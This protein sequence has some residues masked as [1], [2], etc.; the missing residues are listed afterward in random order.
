MHI[1]VMTYTYAMLEFYNAI[2]MEKELKCKMGIKWYCIV[3]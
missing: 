3:I 2:I 1:C